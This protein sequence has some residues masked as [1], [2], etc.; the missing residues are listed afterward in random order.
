MNTPAGLPIPALI[1][2]HLKVHL[3][4]FFKGTRTEVDGVEKIVLDNIPAAILISGPKGFGKRRLAYWLTQ[5]L[6]CTGKTTVDSVCGTCRFCLLAPK[7]HQGAWVDFQEIAPEEDKES[8]SGGSLKIEDF[9][10]LKAKQGFGSHETSYRV[11][12]IRDAEKMTAAAGNSILKIVEE[13]PPGWIFIF[14]V[15]D[16]TMVLP[17]LLSRCQRI[18]V[19]PCPDSLLR[20]YLQ[21]LLKDQSLTEETQTHL[22]KRAQGS[23]EKLASILPSLE[24]QDSKAETTPNTIVKEFLEKPANQFNAVLEWATHSPS[25]FSQL[26]DALELEAHSSLQETKL[27]AAQTVLQSPDFLDKLAQCRIQSA[28]PLNRKLVVQDLLFSFIGNI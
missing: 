16:E 24:G 5:W 18:R 9:R 2:P 25:H 23:F 28:L 11:F 7:S 27:S 1:E 12:L 17:T 21:T 8:R 22:L 19:R 3:R 26:L 13:P 14:T 4:P 6:F 20:A 10:E 15:N